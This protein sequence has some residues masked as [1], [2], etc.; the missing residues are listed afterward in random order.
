MW[1]RALTSDH[2]NLVLRHM[3]ENRKVELLTGPSMLT[4]SEAGVRAQA[5]DKT[6]AALDVIPHA[7]ADG[8]TLRLNAIQTVNEFVGYDL[9]GKKDVWDYVESAGAN[10]DPRHGFGGSPLAAGKPEPIYRLRQENAQ[11]VLWDGQTMVFWGETGTSAPS[12]N[13][14]PI[15]GDLPLMGK[16]YQM[17]PE[18]KTQSL[19]FITATMVDE[20]R[21][22][23]HL[24]ADMPFSKNAVPAQNSKR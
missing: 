13:Q 17:V 8:Y 18:K 10:A 15:L 1:V 2:Y 7:M 22:R 21:K 12:T 24:P 16:L 14:L 6:L 23:K 20:T 11:A 3:E 4:L 5:N 19:I 9:D